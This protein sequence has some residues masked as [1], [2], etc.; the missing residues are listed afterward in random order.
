METK[1][2]ENLIRLDGYYKIHNNL[3]LLYYDTDELLNILKDIKKTF[4]YISH[5]FKYMD[6]SGT[7]KMSIGK[8][9]IILKPSTSCFHI[10]FEKNNNRYDISFYRLES[11]YKRTTLAVD[12]H[13]YVNEY[14]TISFNS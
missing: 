6:L 8:K 5:E 4:S 11:N 14:P 7:L 3:E 13:K 2:Q 12:L 10:I 1:Y 9:T